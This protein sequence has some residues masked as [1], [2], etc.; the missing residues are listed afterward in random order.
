MCAFFSV[1]NFTQTLQFLLELETFAKSRG[2][3]RGLKEHPEYHSFLKRW[4]LA[5]YFEIRN[6]E[7]AGDFE[8]KLK[9]V[10]SNLGKMKFNLAANSGNSTDSTTEPEFSLETTKYLWQS[11][12]KCYSDQIFLPHL[13]H[14]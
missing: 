3:F 7:I 14:R 2:S 1:Q 8:M 4:N 5:V 9:I 12:V 6:R 13:L 10:K 11:L